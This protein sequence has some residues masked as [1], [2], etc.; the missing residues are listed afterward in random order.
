MRDADL[1]VIIVN[2]NSGDY[3]ERCLRSLEAHHG[4]LELDVL[5][6]DNASVDGAHR[7]AVAAHPRVGLIENPVNLFLSPAWNQGIRETSAGYVLLLNPD[8]EWWHGTLADYVRIAE[9]HPNAGIIGPLVRNSDG[10]VYPSG[11]IFP[12]VIDAFGHAFLGTLWPNN[13]FT[14]RYHIDGWDRTSQREVDWVSGCCMLFPRAVFEDVGC[15]DEAF[16]LYGE[17]FDIATRLR[18][19]GWRIIFTPEIEIL[20]EGGVSTGRSRAQLRMHSMGIYRYYR[21]HRARGWRRL[22]LPL[23]W[24]V[25][26]VRADVEWLRI[27]L[28]VRVKPSLQRSRR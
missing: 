13:R 22:T 26:R 18:D 21:K 14:K 6:I 15:F 7:R 3:L 2:Y 19:A 23:A 28:G 20:H 9:E 10:T 16:P 17:E 12:R 11:R 1:A 4:G 8:V 25:L 24:V 27:G 5:V